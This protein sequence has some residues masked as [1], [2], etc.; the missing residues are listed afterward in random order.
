[1]LISIIID[2]VIK[3]NNSEVAIIMYFGI[4]S[5]LL[6]INMPLTPP[7]LLKIHQLGLEIEEK[8]TQRERIDRGIRV[9]FR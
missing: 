7:R 9:N 4:N 2:K 6:L 3:E 8:N 1:M 5:N